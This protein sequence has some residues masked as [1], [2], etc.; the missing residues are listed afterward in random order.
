M[1]L[2][3]PRELEMI[4]TQYLSEVREL[5]VNSRLLTS[6]AFNSPLRRFDR[7]IQPRRSSILP[8]RSSNKRL[9]SLARSCPARGVQQSTF[10]PCKCT[11]PE[12]SGES[13]AG[14]SAWK[15]KQRPQRNT[16]RLCHETGGKL[17]ERAD[18]LLV[19]QRRM[20]VGGGVHFNISRHRT[21]TDKKCSIE[22]RSLT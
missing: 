17:C 14:I 11:Q 4:P 18:A 2:C 15:A 16:S 7:S 20:E 9:S 22:I 8:H 1:R 12:A 19:L 10:V 21:Y 3:V 5:R 13:I 6:A